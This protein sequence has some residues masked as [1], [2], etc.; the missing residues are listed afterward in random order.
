MTRPSLTLRKPSTI[1]P[2]AMTA[3]VEGSDERDE[4]QPVA[5]ISTVIESSPV[6]A[7]RSVPSGTAS[8]VTHAC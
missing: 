4:R 6:P 1:S 2:E 3:F 7:L 5:E 8:V